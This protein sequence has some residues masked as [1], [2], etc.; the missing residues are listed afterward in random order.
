MP[1]YKEEFEAEHGNKTWGDDLYDDL[2]KFVNHGE[3]QGNLSA[4]LRDENPADLFDGSP[5]AP[6]PTQAHVEYMK[7]YARRE[8]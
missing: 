4:F 5:P 3:D 2:E 1:T 7:F 8:Y 6:E